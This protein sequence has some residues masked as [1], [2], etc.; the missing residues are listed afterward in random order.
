MAGNGSLEENANNVLA[1]GQVLG[2]FLQPFS[3]NLCVTKIDVAWR[4]VA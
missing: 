1:G 4:P 3:C 2:P